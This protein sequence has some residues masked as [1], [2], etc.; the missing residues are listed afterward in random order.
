MIATTFVD[1]E[2]VR[3]RL[4]VGDLEEFITKCGWTVVERIEGVDDAAKAEI[5]RLQSLPCIEAPE[6]SSAE[7]KA[8]WDARVI[9]EPNAYERRQEARRERYL[10][11]AGSARRESDALATRSHAMMSVI[12]MGQP[13]LV[14]HHSEKRDR[15]YR[16]RAWNM[17]G[18]A[19]AASEKAAHYAQKAASVGSGGISS[20]DPDSVAKL[21][22][23]LATLEALQEVMKQANAII[24]RKL[25]DDAKVAELAKLPGISEARAR[26]LLKPDYCGRI[27][28]AS[29]ELQN[30]GANVRRIAERI[31]YLEAK[32]SE[33]P[34]PDIEGQLP[35][36]MRWVIREDTDE[37]RLLIEFEGKPPEEVR[38]KLKS[39]GFRWS[40][41]RNAWCRQL[42]NAARWNAKYVMGVS[43]NA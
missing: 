9:R 7:H 37:N 8:W 10:E 24:R 28:F 22:E 16:D 39:Y 3:L 1:G 6:R 34:K 25:T 40:P 11:R 30:N 33:Q 2:K 27:G 4:N 19:V 42:N 17:M 43:D 20:D 26:E 12:P 18:K 5:E 32:A 15:N 41:T 13:I 29:Y 36:G 14:G 23:K 21:R 35:C 31:K 38:S